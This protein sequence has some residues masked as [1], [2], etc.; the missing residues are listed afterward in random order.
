[1]TIAR[2]LDNVGV[3]LRL[4]SFQVDPDPA[5]AEADLCPS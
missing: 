3:S 1:L 5:A 4:R 2:F